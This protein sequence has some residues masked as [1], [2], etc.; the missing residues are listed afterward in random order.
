MAPGHHSAQATCEPERS[1]PSKSPPS[2]LWARSAWQFPSAEFGAPLKLQPQPGSQLQNSR[3]VPESFQSAISDVALAD[4]LPSSLSLRRA[5]SLR[6]GTSSHAP[7]Q[8]EVGTV[9]GQAPVW[10]VRNSSGPGGL[11]LKPDRLN[12]PAPDYA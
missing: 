12:E 5:Y 3:Y 10:L 7:G 2:I 1:T 6:R 11:S 8:T 4:Y 9:R